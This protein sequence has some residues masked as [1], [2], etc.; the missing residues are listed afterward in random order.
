MA[1]EALAW[2]DVIVSLTD[3]PLVGVWIG[4]QRSRAKRPVR[5]IEWTMD[6]FPEAFAAAKL[7]GKNNPLYRLISASQRKHFSDAYICL[8][9]AQSN[10]L[11]RL[12]GIDRPTVVLPCG[13]VEAPSEAGKA[14]SWRQEEQRIVI[15]Y[16]GNLGEAHC[17]YFL[18]V[19]VESADP[20][21]F[22]FL[23]S[24][25]G[26]HAEGVRQRLRDRKNI[27]WRDRIS[28]V[29][30]L[31]ADVHAASLR[32][33]WTHVCVPSKAVTTVCLG[34]PLLFAGDPQSDTVGMLGRASWMLPIPHDG[35]YDREMILAILEEIADPEKRTAKAR[36]ARLLAETLK[37]KKSKALAEIGDLIAG[38]PA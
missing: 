31:H 38:R 19:L 30:L 33:D 37:I 32:S 34:R 6:L 2:A 17:P 27:L 4:R 24:L 28:H 9:E 29:E 25:Y 35:R 3:P 12:R 20:E 18:P 14:P 36:E 22:A 11:R 1:R 13:I 26:I 10:A 8:G 5:W 23:F 15:A 16:A 21:R 7:V